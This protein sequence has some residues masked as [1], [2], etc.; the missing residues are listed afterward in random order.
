MFEF[1]LAEE[2]RELRDRVRAFATSVIAPGVTEWEAA[3]HIPD[4]VGSAFHETGIAARYLTGELA[5]RYLAEIC[6]VTEE[7]AYACPAVASFLMLPVFFN[8]L[9]LRYLPTDAAGRLRTELASGHVMTAFAASERVAGSDLRSMAVTASRTATGY[10]LDGRK[11]Y[12]SNARRASYLIIVA[13]GPDQ[14]LPDEA[15]AADRDRGDRGEPIAPLSWFVVQAGCAGLAFGPRWSTLGLRAIDV[16][17]IELDG[18]EALAL[19]GV[20]GEG[21]RMLNDNLA[22]SRTGIAAVGVG[23]AR[24]ARD[25]V[26]EF[27]SRRRVF[28]ERL[29]RMQDYR[30][31]IADMEAQ[32]AAARGLVS[33]SARKYDAGFDN[34]KEASIAKLVS[35]DMVMR[36]TEAAVLMLGSVGY[37]GQSLVEKLLRDARHVGIVEGPEPIHREIVFAELLRRGAY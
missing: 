1:E 34:G 25:L 24:R 30:F 16:S 26:L 36:V 8:R 32:I 28:G 21:L 9:L 4:S 5:R 11:E 14:D 7:L 15:A 13:R 12:S 29:T 18:A 27:G 23:I 3:G 31:R 10:R 22:Q 37:T 2:Q 6:M 35:G 20:E 17:P 33:L 19:L